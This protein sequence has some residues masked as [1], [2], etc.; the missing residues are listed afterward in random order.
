MLSGSKN[1]VSC[2]KLILLQSGMVIK[3]N[4]HLTSQ[5]GGR[6]R[7]R[8]CS[9]PVRVIR[10]LFGTAGLMYPIILLG[11]DEKA[12]FFKCCKGGGS[13]AMMDEKVLPEKLQDGWNNTFKRG[14]FFNFALTFRLLD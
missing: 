3:F 2:S 8:S 5:H 1:H 4:N 14:M 12:L 6:F 9:Y 7:N 10:L 13:Y 11:I